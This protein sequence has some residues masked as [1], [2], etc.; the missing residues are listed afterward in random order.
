MA[1]ARGQDQD[2]FFAASPLR[3]AA[4]VVRFLLELALLAGVAVLVLRLVPDWWG[5]VVAA[6]AVVAVAVLWGLFLSPKAPVPLPPLAGLAL[7]A[8]LFAV[9]LGI[10]AAIG[11]AAWILDRAVLGLGA[12]R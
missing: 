11:V 3:K 4:L 5:W 6:V 7:E 10:P 9:G 2:P 1:D 8:G 12:Q